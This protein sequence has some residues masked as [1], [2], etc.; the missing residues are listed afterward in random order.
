M[1]VAKIALAGLAVL[2]VAACVVVQVWPAA[3]PG[4]SAA[5]KA[6]DRDVAVTAAATNVTKAFLDVDYSDMDPRIAKVLA[7]STG[8][9]KNQYETAKVDL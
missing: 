4:A 8:T 2:L 1:R 5:E 3:V 6:D 7:L 9:F